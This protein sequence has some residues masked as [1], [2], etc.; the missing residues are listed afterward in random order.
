M[1]VLSMLM[2][3][4]IHCAAQAEPPTRSEFQTLPVDELSQRVLGDVG[5]LVMGV[6]RSNF[7]YDIG[8]YTRAYAPPTQ[9][10]L[11]MSDW[12]TVRLDFSADGQSTIESIA[13]APRFGAVDSIYRRPGVEA[14]RANRRLCSALS[15][16]T[17]FFPAPDWVA[18]RG[19]LAY[20]DYIK[21]AKAFKHRDYAFECTGACTGMDARSYIESIDPKDITNIAIIDC[22]EASDDRS[23]YKVSLTGSP[24]GMFPRELRLYGRGYGVNTQVS[25]AVL[26]I[27]VTMF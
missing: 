13:A 19:V 2:L 11:C 5:A 23:C 3:A 22:V 7:P 8:F 26:W 16:T 6:D 17:R 12:I 24:P 9:Y 25:R 10:G 15:D 21:G 14:E 27:G 18:A 1:R 20:L 4:L